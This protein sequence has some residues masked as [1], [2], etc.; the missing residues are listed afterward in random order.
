MRLVQNSVSAGEG[1]P[2]ELNRSVGAGFK[3]AQDDP[4]RN[5]SLV[6]AKCGGF[7]TRPYEFPTNISKW[8]SRF[9][10]FQM[11][12]K[13]VEG[14]DN[15]RARK[16]QEN[17]ARKPAGHEEPAASFTLSGFIRLLLII[18]IIVAMVIFFGGQLMQ[19]TRS[20]EKG[21]D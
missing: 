18:L 11:F 17:L 5:E 21:G 13:K 9:R 8:F 2:I 6:D 12:M 10:P 19:I 4:F 3:P 1:N 20:R 15:L 16:V 7:E 14:S